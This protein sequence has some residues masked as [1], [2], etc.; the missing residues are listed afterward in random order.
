MSGGVDICKQALVVGNG[1]GWGLDIPP[2]KMST[3]QHLNYFFFS[4]LTVEMTTRAISTYWY[5]FFFCK[6]RS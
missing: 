1:M 3:C 4:T 5:L 2:E 6:N